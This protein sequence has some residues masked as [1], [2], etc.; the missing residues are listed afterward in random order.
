MDSL[1][2][3]SWTTKKRKKQRVIM[4]NQTPDIDSFS[5]P[6]ALMLQQSQIFFDNWIKYRG[7]PDGERARKN[8]EHFEKEIM[9]Y[10]ENQDALEFNRGRPLI[11]ENP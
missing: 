6:L 10:L 11:K 9:K 7:T 1:A 4:T 8:L 5:E 3:K 2:R